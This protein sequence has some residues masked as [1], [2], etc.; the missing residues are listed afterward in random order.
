[1]NKK[2]YLKQLSLALTLCC[3]LPVSPAY[4]AANFS[5]TPTI[6]PVFPSSINPGEMV[7]AYYTITNKTSS[8]RAGYMIQGLPASVT[9][10]TNSTNPTYCQNQ[11]TLIAGGSCILLLQISKPVKSSFAL[12][13]GNS[14][15]TAAT[16]LNVKQSTA[17][18]PE[19]AGGQYS[20]GS[21]FYPLLADSQNGGTTWIYPIEKS[22]P[23]P[24][25]FTDLGTFNSVSCSGLN[26]VAGGQYNATPSFQYPLLANSQNGGATWTYAI[27]QSKT[28]PPGYNNNGDFETVSCS[29]LNCIAGGRYFD[30]SIFYPLLANSQNGGLSWTYAID[31]SSSLPSGFADSGNFSSLSCS[32]LN[33]VAGGQYSDAS[34]PFI[35]YP[36]LANSQNGGAT[37][38][39]VID[40]SKTL[41]AGFTNFGNFS[42]VSCSGL[43]CV[44]GG[45]YADNFTQYPILANSQ[46]GG[47]TWTFVIDKSKALPSGYANSG[48]F[49]STSC[50]GLNCVAA[51][52]Y[53]DGST[54]YPLLANSQ[55]GGAAWTYAID[56]SKTLPSGFATFGVFYSVSCSGLHCVAGGQYSDGSIFY[57]LL[58]YSQNGGATWTYVIDKSKTLPSGF[59]TFGI[60][61]SASCSGLNC[62]AG[63]TYSNGSTQYPLLAISQDGGVTWIY[64]ID[65][66]KTLPFDFNN[67]GFIN[68]VVVSSLLPESLALIYG[69]PNIAQ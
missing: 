60:F 46:N 58:A 8:T 14:C 45:F 35:Q 12:C 55:N 44:A 63:G 19:L 68:S 32:G 47:V 42:G 53:S 11:I 6:G 27:D 62:I 5:I 67:G 30:G 2:Y 40:K 4:A 25:G 16:D 51:G 64:S 39:Y 28:L 36:L 22:K 34:I 26:C 52:Q 9:Q 7:F 61:S 48:I 43:N 56:K 69:Y 21:T 37:W 17:Q 41:P 20:D 1:M 33:C 65:K 24:S 3:A 31:K 15:T 29:G 50:S 10:V 66:S 13:K 54:S 18:A 49:Y 38:T 57:P 59:A 23:L